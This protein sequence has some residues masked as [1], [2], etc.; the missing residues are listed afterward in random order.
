[1]AAAMSQAPGLSGTPDWGQRSSAARRASWAR[2]SATPTSPVIRARPAMSLADS[3]LQTASIARWV[4]EM[5]AYRLAL[6]AACSMIRFSCSRSSG[7]NSGPKSSASNTWRI[8]S[9]VSVPG[10]VK[11][12]RFT[13]S[14]ASSLDLT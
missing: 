2:S 13:H 10:S 6:A 9:S 14:I 4:S 12:A 7:V 8:S 1:L 5:G 3:I 11:G